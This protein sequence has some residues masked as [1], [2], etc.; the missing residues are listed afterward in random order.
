MGLVS[1][2]ITRRR[3]DLD[4]WDSPNLFEAFCFRGGWR[5]GD[6]MAPNISRNRA[7]CIDLD[8]HQKCIE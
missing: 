7:N 3:V 4:G 1:Q 5:A 6:R 8:L 2:V